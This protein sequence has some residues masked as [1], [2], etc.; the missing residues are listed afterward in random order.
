[1][2]GS[3]A[4]AAAAADRAAVHNTGMPPAARTCCLLLVQMPVGALGAGQE[5]TNNLTTSQNIC[6][7]RR[8]RA[9]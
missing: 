5:A 1:M 3:N 7:M 6:S 4:A 2:T 8:H 9:V